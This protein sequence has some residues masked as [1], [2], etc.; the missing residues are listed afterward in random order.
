MK[1]LHAINDRQIKYN[2]FANNK[3]RV[4]EPKK[5][6]LEK[7]KLAVKVVFAILLSLVLLWVN[8]GIFFISFVIGV[9]FSKTI[10]KAIE[11][12]K[13]F[14]LN[15]K[16]PVAVGMGILAVLVLPVFIATGSAIWSAYVGSYLSQ[17]VLEKMKIPR[18]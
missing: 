5:T 16:L 6:T 8:P 13:M 12:I 1:I 18:D 4:N 10:Q 14:I 15:Y 3:L 7:V 2:L 17:W 9:A 11:K